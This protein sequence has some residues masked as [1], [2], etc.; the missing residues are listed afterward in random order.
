MNRLK[1]VS[2]K[3][4]PDWFERLEELTKKTGLTQSAIIR[5]VIGQYLGLD[6]ISSVDKKVDPL[7]SEIED[8][9]ARLTTLEGGIKR[10]PDS[11]I[12][13]SK[14]LKQSKQ[15]KRS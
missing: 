8:I 3:V 7:R 10:S 13:T 11:E 4:P 2:T 6:T 12:K 14:R 15:S 1:L 5:D 9:K